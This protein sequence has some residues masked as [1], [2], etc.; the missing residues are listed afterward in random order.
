MNI[1]IEDKNIAFAVDALMRAKRLFPVDVIMQVLGL[2]K[3]QAKE[4]INIVKQLKGV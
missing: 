2:T 3:S 4:A 1:K